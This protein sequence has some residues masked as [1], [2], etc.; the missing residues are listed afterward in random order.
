MKE[1]TQGDAP[2]P[3]HRHRLRLLVALGLLAAVAVGSIGVAVERSSHPGTAPSR[4]NPNTAPVG[5]GAAAPPALAPQGAGAN[6]APSDPQLGIYTGPG[7]AATATAVDRRL[8]GKVHYALEF[9]SRTSWTAMADTS[10]VQAAWVGSGFDLVIGVPMLPD[11]EGTMADGAHGDY[12]LEFSLLAQR[13][14]SAGLGGAVLMVGWQPDDPGNP[15]YVTSAAEATNY[16]AYWGDIAR[17]MASVAGAHFVF[18][19]DAGDSDVSP[20]SPARMYPGDAAVDMVATD[21]FDLVPATVPADEQWTAVLDRPYG[22]AWMASFAAEHDKPLALAMW[23]VAPTNAGG[24]GDSPAFVT[25]LLGWAGTV[26]AS[27]CVL[28]DYGK[29]AVTDGAFPAAESQL[30]TALDA[31]TASARGGGT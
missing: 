6:G 13:L 29:W 30:S 5:R 27:M 15:W 11:G 10:W 16:V 31:G 7:S 20:L 24:G 9:L 8:D 1:L 2:P 28:W 26:R 3:V 17:T 4:T 12:D 19:W 25:Q 22:P 18:E 21:A 14:V 23:G